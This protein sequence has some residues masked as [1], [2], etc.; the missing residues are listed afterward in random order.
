[1]LESALGAADTALNKK[2]KILGFMVCKLGGDKNDKQIERNILSLIVVN[3]KEKN[4][5]GKRDEKSQDL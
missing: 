5:A 2:I 4:K 3:A 1:M